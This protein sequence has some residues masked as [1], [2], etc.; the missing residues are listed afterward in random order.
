MNETGNDNA[1]FKELRNKFEG[2]ELPP[3][4]TLWKSIS[5]DLEIAD[6]RFVKR[7][8]IIW[9]TLA[10]LSIGL[11]LLFLGFNYS[12]NE[13]PIPDS[14]TENNKPKSDQV[15]AVNSD[16]RQNNL[17][18]TNLESDSNNLESAQ[19]RTE[20]RA[21]NQNRA[22]YRFK[23][24]SV[25]LTESS[26]LNM[27]RKD[28][29]E[30]ASETSLANGYK[31]TSTSVPTNNKD[32][33]AAEINDQFV[34]NLATS[35]LTDQF[36]QDPG[37]QQLFPRKILDCLM[38]DRQVT[39]LS[40]Q[41]LSDLQKS[42]SKVEQA[43]FIHVGVTPS[44]T[45]RILSNQQNV[46][47]T[48]FTKEY[49]NS[50]ESGRLNYN[51]S[52]ELGY[53]LNAHFSLRTGVG[54]TNYST[55]FSGFNMPVQY[56]TLNGLFIAN[57]S[58]GEVEFNDSDFEGNEEDEN[59]QNNTNN[60]ELEDVED[61]Q[62]LLSYSSL[63]KISYVQIPLSF[64][65]GINRNKWRYYA[66]IGMTFNFLTTQKVE[67]AFDN[68][69]IIRQDNSLPIRTFNVGSTIG[70]GIEYR[71]LKATSVYLEPSFN[72]NFLNIN[73]LGSV[74]SNPYSVGTNL[75]FKIYF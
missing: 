29:L 53:R 37:M 13:H 41:V 5:K 35:N 64:E 3:D 39:A 22:A 31:S 26:E 50:R 17:A 24:S 63:Q 56:D 11:L 55:S 59:E 42:V 10:F 74:R 12:N 49:Y 23:N 68:I 21:L 60:E 75:G 71:F 34:A 52:A 30:A 9:R 14:T 61:G 19:K 43:F 65:A 18:A 45:H 69:G 51:Y 15:K 16:N 40:D 62:I 54:M 8:L 20:L 1:P 25:V 72:Y 28:E 44:Y 7:K 46:V 73:R 2:H 48:V 66:T 70:M 58:N 27:F 36:E 4:A 67:L 33:S 57:T 32:N 38:I 6:G 47:P